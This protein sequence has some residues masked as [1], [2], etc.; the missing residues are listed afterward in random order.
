MF[1]LRGRFIGLHR[2]ITAI[3]NNE[4]V[5][6]GNVPTPYEQAARRFERKLK[7]LA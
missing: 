4:E 1:E 3:E 5:K 2:K 6:Y 7:Q